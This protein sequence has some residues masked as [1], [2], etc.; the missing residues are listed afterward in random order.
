MV[1]SDSYNLL[2]VRHQYMA[3]V[4]NGEGVM[5]L[6]SFGCHTEGAAVASEPIGQSPT[7]MNCLSPN[8]SSV[9]VEKL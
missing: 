4:L 2:S 8:I 7:T 5:V 9:E 6:P 3:E 1:N